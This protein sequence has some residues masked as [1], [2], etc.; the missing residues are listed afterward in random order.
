M[1]GIGDLRPEDELLSKAW[2]LSLALL[3]SLACRSG[4]TAD[5]LAR[6]PCDGT[7]AAHIPARPGDAPSGREFLARIAGLDGD[8]RE[9]MIREQLLAGNIPGFLR[10]LQPVRFEAMRSDGQPTQITLCVAPDYLAIGSDSDFALMPMRLETALQIADRFGFTLP[11]PKMVDAIYRQ[12]SVQYAPQP[13]PAGDTM[14]STAYYGMHNELVAEQRADLGAPRGELSAGDKKDLVI[15][16][17]LWQH[18]DRVAIYGWHLTFA[19]PIQPLS[20][21]HGW[22][23]AD[24]SHGARLVSLE[25]FADGARRSLLDILQDPRLAGAVSSEGVIPQLAELLDALSTMH[26]AQSAHADPGR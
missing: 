7:L 4:Y 14:R 2:P 23:Y 21:V 15:T 1:Y 16:G 25:A 11:T 13:L 12:A 26:T 3:A 18:L 9:A 6:G 20:T 8:A 10:Q 19:H 5:T 22:H 17:R 24:Y